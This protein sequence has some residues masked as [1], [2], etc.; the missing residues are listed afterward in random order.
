MES[1]QI[2]EKKKSS[3]IFQFV[4]KPA[5]HEDK[6]TLVQIITSY[7]SFRENQMID[8]KNVLQFVTPRRSS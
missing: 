1:R 4:K 2:Q 6:S 8:G 5:L 3:L 7:L